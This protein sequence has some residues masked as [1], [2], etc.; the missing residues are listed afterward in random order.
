MLRDLLTNEYLSRLELLDIS[1][2]KR[3]SSAS[4]AGCKKVFGKRLFIGI[5]GF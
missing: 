2:R 4:S 3:L 5:F 1:I